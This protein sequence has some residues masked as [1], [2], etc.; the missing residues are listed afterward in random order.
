MIEA[1][2]NSFMRARGN[3]TELKNRCASASARDRRS[4]GIDDSQ[5]YPLRD[6]CGTV[7]EC[8]SPSISGSALQLA[9]SPNRRAA[10]DAT[11][12][13]IQTA[14]GWSTLAVYNRLGIG[15]FLGPGARVAA[16]DLPQQ[17]LWLG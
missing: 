15:T 17:L 10:H 13:R 4:K 7:L 12:R 3:R 16:W 5:E 11:G 1:S 14:T 8:C 9:S 6:E 2:A